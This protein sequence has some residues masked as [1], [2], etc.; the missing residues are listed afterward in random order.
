MLLVILKYLLGRVE[1]TVTPNSQNWG[2]EVQVS[3]GYMVGSCFKNK[4]SNTHRMI[5][6][7]SQEILVGKTG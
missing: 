6:A 3:L 5:I 2:C 4:P 1:Y 7:S